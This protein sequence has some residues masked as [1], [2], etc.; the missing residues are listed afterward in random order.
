MAVVPAHFL[1]DVYAKK[2]ISR[3]PA[4]PEGEVCPSHLLPERLG[5][6]LSTCQQSPHLKTRPGRRRPS[7]ISSYKNKILRFRFMVRVNRHPRG[8]LPAL[9]QWNFLEF[10]FNPQREAA[11][12]DIK[13]GGTISA[14]FR[15]LQI[16]EAITAQNI[17]TRRDGPNNGGVRENREF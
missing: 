8:F 7:N 3:D 11:H 4:S 1:K 17:Q 14:W 15:G 12:L 13:L 5:P 6:G 10:S 2:S 9:S 16:E